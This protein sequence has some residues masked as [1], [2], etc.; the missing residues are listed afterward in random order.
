MWINVTMK[1]EKVLVLAP[2]TDDGELGC[3]GTIARKIEEGAE[4]D[5]TLFNPNLKWTFAESDIKSKSKN[6]PFV[7][8]DF[9]GK[10]LGI[11]N[12]GRLQLN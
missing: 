9:T 2:H 8:T 1:K 11:I 10:A 3:G 7:G 5:L 4:A 6:T 12:K